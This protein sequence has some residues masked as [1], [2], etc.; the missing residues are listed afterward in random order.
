[1]NDV[2]MRSRYTRGFVCNLFMWSLPAAILLSESTAR[3]SRP[4]FICKNGIKPERK[5]EYSNEEARFTL[6]AYAHTGLRSSPV[7][8]NRRLDAD[9]GRGRLNV[10]PFCAGL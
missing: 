5:H 10:S 9:D 6:R 8:V 2:D 4:A 1:M 7:T 3:R